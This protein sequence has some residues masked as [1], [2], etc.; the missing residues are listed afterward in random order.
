MFLSIIIP[1]FNEASTVTQVLDKLLALKYPEFISGTEI[2]IIDDC[3]TDSTKEII[4]KYMVGKEG[5]LL[6]EQPLNMGKGAAVRKG[7]AQAAGDLLVIQDADLELNPADIVKML[8]AM[9]DL[10]V[11]F[12]NG[13]RYLPGVIRPLSTYYRYLGNR[14]F[15]F[16]TSILINV[17]LTDMACAYKLVHKELL[18][19]I[20]LRENRFGFEAELIIKAMR[21]KRNNIIE[22]PVQYFPRD[23]QGGKK[24]RSTDAFKIIWTIIKYG[25]IRIK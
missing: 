9:Q 10:G 24:L 1:A 14:L 4:K 18:E 6:L 7:F 19:K 23:K 16:L 21:I 12:V 3:S 2:I 22:I 13:S 5:L 15:T 11:Q 8:E 17:K 25:L 20:T